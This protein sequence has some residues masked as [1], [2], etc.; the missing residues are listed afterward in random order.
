MGVT[1]SIPEQYTKPEGEGL[2]PK[3]DNK[4]GFNERIPIILPKTPS[5]G[6]G[7]QKS[8][9][10]SPEA[11]PALRSVDGGG[12]RTQKNKKKVKFSRK[13]KSIRKL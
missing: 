7:G 5:P 13:N 2:L 1:G 3:I 4:T 11:L 10:K 9:R 6:A 8:N 12:K